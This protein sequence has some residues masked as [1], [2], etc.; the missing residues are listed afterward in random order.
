MPNKNKFYGNVEAG[1]LEQRRIL[2]VED[3]EGLN[4]LAQKSLRRAGFD[5]EGVLTGSHALERIS[6]NPDLIMLIDQQLPDMKGTELIGTLRKNSM[7]IPFVAMTGH[8]DEALAIAMMKLG[9]RDYLIKGFDFTDHLPEVFQRLCRELHTEKRLDSAEKALLQSEERFKLAMEATQDGL[10]DWNVETD[11]MYLS[12]S[13]SA[14]LGYTSD[15]LELDINVWN[16]LI[17]TDDKVVV[18]KAYSDCIANHNDGFEVEYRVRGKNGEWVWILGRG[19]VVARSDSGRAPRMVGTLTDITRLKLGETESAIQATTLNTIFNSTPSILILVNEEHR[20][21]KINYSGMVF[22]A[23]K[24]E[25]LIGR[26]AGDILCCIDALHGKGCGTTLNCAKCPVRTRV[27]TTFQT[28]KPCHEEDK[29][30][31]LLDDEE[32]TL[33][34]LIS[35]VLLTLGMSKIVLVTLTN[36]SDLKRAESER[37]SL[38]QQL[39][40]SLKIQSIGTLAGGIAHDFNN[41]LTAILG[42]TEMAKFESKQEPAL[43]EDLSQV[44]KAGNR[45]KELVQQILVFSRQSETERISLQ[46]GKVVKEAIK[47]LR[48]SL[49][50]TIVISQS[51]CQPMGSILADPTQ[52]HQIIMNICTNA[53]HAMEDTGGKLDISLKETILNNE[54]IGYKHNIEAGVFVQISIADTGHGIAKEIIDK[55][56]DPYFTT[57]ETGKGTGMGLSIVHGIVLSYGG[58]VT[59]DSEPGKGTTV[60]VFLPVIDKKPLAEA[61]VVDEIILGNEKIL[62]VDDEEAIV[63]MNKKMLEKLGYHVT[64]SKNSLDAW[65][66]FQAQPNQFDLVITDQTMPNMTGCDLARNILQIRPD[67]PIILCTGYSTIINEKE[68]KAIGISAFVTKPVSNNN[69]S[70][71]IRTV[72]DAR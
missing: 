63:N 11:E 53:Y 1:A 21:H 26:L 12:P 49:P 54:D 69:L 46:P 32:T 44:I 51:F 31:F 9:A 37:R 25:E 38:E 40:Q 45:A 10:W 34:L 71:L 36:I 58:F 7:Y 42:Y 57:K 5:T 22:S 50:S 16:N 67:I 48:P 59:L 17:H 3:D 24:E 55:I 18:F 72:V 29:M 35:T 68:A 15:T 20:V 6:A 43:H 8:G 19:K 28:G 66:T 70:T 14:L 2:V 4:N 33:D 39:R 23:K 52:L 47:M 41:I 30:T 61:S 65:E 27:E 60:H 62:F 64:A 13:C 56:F